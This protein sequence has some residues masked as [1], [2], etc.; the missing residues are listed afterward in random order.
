M[1]EL[2]SYVDELTKQLHYAL[3]EEK[4]TN[5]IIDNLKALE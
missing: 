4:E 2:I 3:N 1:D 5:E